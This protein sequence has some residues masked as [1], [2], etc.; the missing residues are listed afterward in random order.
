V[1]VA[2][3]KFHTLRE[4]PTSFPWIGKIGK[5]EIFKKSYATC[6]NMHANNFQHIL[7]TENAQT[8]VAYEKFHTLCEISTSF[9]QIGE[10][11]ALR[12]FFNM[13]CV[14]LCSPCTQTTPTP[15]TQ[16]EM[17]P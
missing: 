4:I 6:T 10:N 17:I 15:D 16:R 9:L 8:H 3:V 7:S 5:V 11:L 1:Q 14:T 13:E 2:D 12:N